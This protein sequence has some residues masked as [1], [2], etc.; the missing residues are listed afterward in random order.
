MIIALLNNPK[1]WFIHCVSVELEI[2]VKKRKKGVKVMSKI[3][4][5]ENEAHSF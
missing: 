1:E 3:T 4:V 2:T 5:K